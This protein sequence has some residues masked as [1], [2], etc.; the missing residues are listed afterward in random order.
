MRE[1]AGVSS[2]RVC[3]QHCF[4][5]KSVFM[6]TAGIIHSVCRRAPGHAGTQL[7]AFSPYC[8]GKKRRPKK[9]KRVLIN[10][11]FVCFQKNNKNHIIFRFVSTSKCSRHRSF[12][13]SDSAFMWV[14]NSQSNPDVS[15]LYKPRHKQG[16]TTYNRNHG[17][18][19]FGFP[20]GTPVTF[21]Q[22]HT[23]APGLLW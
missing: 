5:V 22:G 19:I 10:H 4:A 8:E 14:L 13:L 17:P 15:N 3:I 18:L 23:T 2:L 9:K 7:A 21:W 16:I 1:G 6:F 12:L 11:T 20:I